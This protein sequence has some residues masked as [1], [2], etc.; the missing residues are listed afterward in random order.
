[1]SSFTKPESDLLLNRF[2]CTLNTPLGQEAKLEATGIRLPAMTKQI[3]AGDP[4]PVEEIN[5]RAL[6]DLYRAQSAYKVF[7]RNSS[8]EILNEPGLAW[9]YRGFVLITAACTVL[10]GAAWL[11]SRILASL[12]LAK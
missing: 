9:Y 7:G 4:E 5:E 10:L 1:V 11:G 2:Y 8:V 3:E 6:A 12:S